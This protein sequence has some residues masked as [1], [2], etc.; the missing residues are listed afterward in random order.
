MVRGRPPHDAAQTIHGGGR[1]VCS[2]DYVELRDDVTYLQ[3]SHV[4]NKLYMLGLV[5]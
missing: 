2:I 1:I 3:D 4:I 5:S